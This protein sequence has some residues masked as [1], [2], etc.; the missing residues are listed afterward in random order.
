MHRWDAAPREAC[1]LPPIA[2]AL[3]DPTPP[4]AAYRQVGQGRTGSQTAIVTFQVRQRS[5]SV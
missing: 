2:V 3:A 4:T 1:D 5:S